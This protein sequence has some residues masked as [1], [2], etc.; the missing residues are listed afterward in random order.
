MATNKITLNELRSIVRQVINEEM[1]VNYA[2]GKQSI[3]ENQIS[4]NPI[5]QNLEKKAFSF[6]N[7]PKVTA[8]LTKELEKLSPKQKEELSKKALEENVGNDFGSFKSVI[9][10]AL[11]KTDLN[12]DMHDTIRGAAGYKPGEEPSS[13]DKKVGKAI[14]EFGQFNL[15]AMGSLPALSAMALDYFG[16]TDILETISSAVGSGDAA[17]AL[18]IVAGLIGGGILWKLGNIL[19]NKK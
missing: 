14:A 3:K 11:Q 15:A 10:K 19:Q 5:I 6:F 1:E 2:Y 12:E 17:A 8:L 16:G 4:N 7:N 13:L 9:E 18:S